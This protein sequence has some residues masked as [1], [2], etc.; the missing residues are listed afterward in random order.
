MSHGLSPPSIGAQH[1]ESLDTPKDSK[2]SSRKGC[3][4]FDDRD[5][6]RGLHIAASAAC[7]DTVDAWIREK[8][9]V[10][11][12]RFLADLKAFEMLGE[13]TQPAPKDQRARQRRA[14]M[15]KLKAQVRRSRIVR[16]GLV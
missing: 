10:W 7:D 11:I 2:K 1:C 16:Q 3:D 4:D 15:R 5:V 6:L 12:R 9:G 8:T 13:D 14:E